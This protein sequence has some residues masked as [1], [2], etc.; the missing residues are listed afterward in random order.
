MKP[1]INKGIKSESMV[2]GEYKITLKC[3]K[4]VKGHDDSLPFT[5]KLYVNNKVCCDAYHYQW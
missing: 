3:V 4:Q 1:I 2:F 5:A